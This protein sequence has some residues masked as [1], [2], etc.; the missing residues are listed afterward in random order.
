ML[1][2]M[3]MGAGRSAT[4][5]AGGRAG[6]GSEQPAGR[7]PHQ[8]QALAPP[9]GGLPLGKRRELKMRGNRVVDGIPA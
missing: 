5:G 3:P 6:G 4:A 1:S 2:L 8:G 9:L 7:F